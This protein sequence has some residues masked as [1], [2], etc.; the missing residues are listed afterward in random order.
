MLRQRRVRLAVRSWNRSAITECPHVRVTAAP[1]GRI[2]G[3]P[4]A[5]V[6]RHRD[7]AG[8]SAR[9]DARG[10]HDATGLGGLLR[11]MYAIALDRAE[12][13]KRSGV[14]TKKFSRLTSVISTRARGGKARSSSRTVA[15][16]PK[17]PP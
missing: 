4:A 2:D 3:D 12:A 17:P 7:C 9:R 1:H 8:D 14:S 15:T 13:S 10:E 6:V 16:P 5:V 11:E